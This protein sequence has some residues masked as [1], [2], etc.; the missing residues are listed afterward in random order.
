MRLGKGQ[1]L[2]GDE[3][4]DGEILNI[5]LNDLYTRGHGI[6]EREGGYFKGI[7]LSPAFHMPKISLQGTLC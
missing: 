4:G 1:N 5:K 3:N 7:L 2:D 6:S